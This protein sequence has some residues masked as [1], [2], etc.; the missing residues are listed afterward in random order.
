M[1]TRNVPPISLDE[2]RSALEAYAGPPQP[3]RRLARRRPRPWR[4]AGAAAVMLLVFAGASYAAG[5]GPFA[6][7]SAAD[8][9]ATSRDTLPPALIAAI[10]FANSGGEQLGRKVL[11]DTARF[12]TQLP[13][14][15]TIYAVATN[16]GEL[17]VANLAPRSSHANAGLACFPPLDQ[18]QPI[19]RETDGPDKNMPE[20]SYGVAQDGVT[21]VSFMAGGAETTVAVKDNV[22]AYEGPADLRSVTVHYAD[23]ST[24]KVSS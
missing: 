24:Q 2:L 7:I 1:T 13:S 10:N 5:F 8:H 20:V 21:A 6:G 23:G 14:G 4:L 16:T 19:T 9:P 11:P 17:C 3:R 22:W 18:S 15:M 12:V